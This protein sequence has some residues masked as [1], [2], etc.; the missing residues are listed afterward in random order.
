[1]LMRD[2]IFFTEAESSFIQVHV[3]GSTQGY[4]TSWDILLSSTTS[5]GKNQMSHIY[6]FAKQFCQQIIL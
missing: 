6:Y 2:Y 4:C 3:V 5:V 1:M